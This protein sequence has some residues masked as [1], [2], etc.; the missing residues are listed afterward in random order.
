MIVSNEG[1]DPV[2]KAI[3]THAITPG[4]LLPILH[5]IQDA[6]HFIPSEAISRIAHALNLSKAEVHGV[7]TYYHHFRTSPPSGHV[8]QVC[9]AEACQAMGA[10]ALSEHINKHAG[11]TSPL[12]IESVYCLG[13]C[14]SGPALT[15]NGRSYAR[16]TDA[17]FDQ[18]IAEL[19]V[20]S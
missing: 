10:D 9:R 11:T 2:E 6:L 12:C 19:E 15:L 16:L 8:V 7:I 17:V 4:A 1:V 20:E 14:A 18:L 13:L 5:D 3:A